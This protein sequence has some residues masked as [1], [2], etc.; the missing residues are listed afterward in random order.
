[1]LT[2]AATVFAGPVN[3]AFG[4]ALSKSTTHALVLNLAERVDIPK[5]SS[6]CCILPYNLIEFTIF[7][8]L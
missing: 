6:V 7:L 3:Y 1:M 5:T 2:G 4:Y 8:E